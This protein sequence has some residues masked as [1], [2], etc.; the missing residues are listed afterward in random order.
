[1][2]RNNQAGIRGDDIE[3]VSYIIKLFISI[4]RNKQHE[5]NSYVHSSE[6][7]DQKGSPFTLWKTR[8]ARSA[9]QMNSYL[10]ADLLYFV[11][12]TLGVNGWQRCKK[13]RCPMMSSFI[14]SDSNVMHTKKIKK[15]INLTTW[16]LVFCLF[17]LVQQAQHTGP[18]SLRSRQQGQMQFAEPTTSPD[19]S[20]PA[21]SSPG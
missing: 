1:M 12:A 6:R 18:N 14:C 19:N 7:K 3:T 21:F 15:T 20:P 5:D 17:L 13:R 11:I 10:M 8:P 9:V 16:Q 4:V 2:F